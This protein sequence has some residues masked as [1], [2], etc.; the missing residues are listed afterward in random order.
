MYRRRSGYG[1]NF[2]KLPAIKF[3]YS[4][5]DFMKIEEIRK[6]GVAGAGTMG[7]GIVQVFSM[8]GFNVRVVDV[9]ESVWEI[10]GKNITNSL[11]RFIKKGTISEEDK[12]SA[13]ERIS[14]STDIKTL[15]DSDFIIE[16]V[17]ENFNIKKE[18]FEKLDAICRDDVI[19]ASNTS[20]I[21]I[22]E[23]ASVVKRPDKFVGMHFF[24]PVPIMKLVEVIPAIQTSEDTV[25]AA[26]E[27]CKKIG[28]VPVRCKDTPGF[29]VN[30]LLVPF[31]IDAVR[32]YEQGIASKEDIDTALKL[33]AN[34]PMGP[35]EL[36]D[37]TGVDIAY[38]VAEVFFEYLRE[39]RYAPPPLLRQMV[40]AGYLGRKT[41][42][43][44]YN[45]GDK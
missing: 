11:D 38:H 19:Y 6:I 23:M 20:S 43:G 16:A 33:G 35:F 30:R 1:N 28:K 10:A 45:Y 31:M 21:S 24:N 32:M 34:L 9:S 14:F 15:A 44:F 5:G 29:I 26:I 17:F 13:L 22:T 18:L 2:R 39:S 7:S 40:K 41:G 37:F 27:L 4:G 8:S 25:N 12:R 36:M 42:R 3:K